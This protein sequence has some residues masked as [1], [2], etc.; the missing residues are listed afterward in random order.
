MGANEFFILSE[1]D[2]KRY[3]IEREFLRPVVASARLLTKHVK[4][5]VFTEKDWNY[6]R[7]RGEKVYLLWCFKRKGEIR[8]TNVLKY[9]E[10]GEEKG[11]NNRY[12]PRHRPVWY[13][14]ER[15]NP[16]DAFLV[17]MFRRG[18]RLVL[19]EFGALALNTLHCVYFR[20]NVGRDET[21]VKALLAYLNSDVAFKLASRFVRIYGGGMYK[22]EPREAESIP[23]IDPGKLGEPE[24]EALA[25]LF[26]ELDQVAREDKRREVQVRETINNELRRIFS[27]KF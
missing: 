5:Y 11:Y 23:V 8:G 3:G 2:V 25:S 6:A 26:D 4:G 20:E 12:L 17:Y 1:A 14:V 22:L 9:I 7:A 18:I 10:M 19:N 27:L 24:L 16:P 13:W 15:R 21:K